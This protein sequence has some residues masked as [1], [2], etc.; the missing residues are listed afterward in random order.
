MTGRE[1]G[2]MEIQMEQQQPETNVTA[3]DLEK[4]GEIGDKMEGI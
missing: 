3:I 4:R 2:I 1:E